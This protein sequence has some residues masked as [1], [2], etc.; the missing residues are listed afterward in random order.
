MRI[1]FIASTAL[2]AAAGT[3]VVVLL[4]SNIIARGRRIRAAV[5]ARFKLPVLVVVCAGCLA[6]SASPAAAS[7]GGS[8]TG[9]VTN[10]AASPKPLASMCVAALNASTGA[11]VGFITTSATGHYLISGLPTGAYKLKFTDCS[12]VGYLPQYYNN[13]PSFTKATQVAV[14]APKTVT[15]INAKMVLGA[16]VTGTVTNNA[17]SPTPLANMCVY[18]LSAPGMVTST[19]ITNAS[20]QYTIR[21]LPTGSYK[22]EFGDCNGTDYITRYYNNHPSYSTPNSVSVTAPSV[23]SG[24]NAKLVLGGIVTGTVTDNAA[25]P[26]P[27]ADISVS[28]LSSTGSFITGATTP[29]N[30]QYSIAGVPAGSKKVVFSDCAG[31][32]YVPQYYDNQP[33]LAA[34]NTVS[35]APGATNA[36]INAEMVP[37]GKISGTV[38]NNASAPLAHVCVDALNASTGTVIDNATT[39]P[40]GQYTIGSLPAGPYKVQFIDCGQ[41]GFI[42]QYY[43]NQDTFAAA[44]PVSVTSGVTTI[45]ISAKLAHP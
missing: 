15:G 37:A 44:N 40:N 3:T 31:G 20:G 41:Q 2:A 24:I 30:G 34:A 28:V 5:A 45:G 13:K 21:A 43:N 23:I 6:A 26:A 1:E 17:A 10:S 4:G 38:T 16:K 7:G 9:T 42:A 33:S 22:I 19:G 35:V 12:G 29:A 36:G 27:L 18:A 32:D 8:I 11:Q 39:N 14:T 25:S